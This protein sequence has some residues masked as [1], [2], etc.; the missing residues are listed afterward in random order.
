MRRARERLTLTLL[1]WAFAS[2]AY[3]ADCRLGE[4]YV[5][6]A[7]ERVAADDNEQ[8]ITY[9]RRAVDVC[10][11]YAAWQQLAEALSRSPEPGDKKAAVEAF[12][13][14]YELAAADAERARSLHRYAGFLSRE[15]DPQNAYPVI[16]QAAALAGADPEIAA[17]AREID[18]Q[19]QNPTREQLVRGLSASLYK[20]FKVAAS[21]SPQ[22][23]AAK[24][25]PSQAA[26]GPSVNIRVNFETASTVVDDTTRG[27]V[28]LLARALADP[29]LTGRRFLLVGHADVRGDAAYNLQLS[30]DRAA[31]IHQSIVLIEPGLA[32]RIE[33]TGRGSSEPMVSGSSPDAHRAN[34]R[35]QV[36]VR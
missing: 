17:L 4:R 35:L 11:N 34:R 28:R 5:A 21:D 18:Q 36:V 3:A 32:G 30:Q 2:V 16:M 24:S 20:P 1:L 10:P 23:N 13:T 22:P 29:E 9:L 15:G 14:S 26:S 33:T 19:I 7:A 8:A 6:S 31:A 12:V 25:P 27:N